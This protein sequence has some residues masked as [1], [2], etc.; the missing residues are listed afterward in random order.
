MA[1][2]LILLFLCIWSLSLLAGSA[3]EIPRSV[4]RVNV[5]TQA[6]D[7][8]QPWR[9]KAPRTRQALGAVLAD[10]RI[11]VTAELVQNHTYIEIEKPG[12]E[13]KTPAELEV[14]DYSANLALVSA[15]DPE[16]MADFRPLKLGKPP[17]VEHQVE[18]W[19]LQKNDSLLSTDALLTTVQAIMY[20]RGDLRLPAYQLT[21]SL[22]SRSGSFA[23]P[24]I[25]K[26]K[27]VGMVT[28]FSPGNQSMRAI[29]L[30]V[31]KHFFADMEDG[32]YDGFPSLGVSLSP[33]QD[34]QFRKYVGLSPQSGGV[35]ITRVAKGR[36]GEKAGLQT[37]DVI[38]KV[39]GY[40]IDQNGNY[41]HRKY[42][43]IYL[44]NLISVGCQA[45]DSLEL[46]IRRN[47]K[48]MNIA[49]VPQRK[50]PSDY[51]SPPYV[52]DT[53]P[54]YII[55]GGLVI[56]ELSQQY[57]MSW[58]KN[59]QQKAPRKLVYYDANQSSL[60]PEGDRKIVFLS[61]VLPTKATVGYSNLQQLVITKVN[62][63][64]IRSLDDVQKAL[65]NAD[66]GL[67]TFKFEDDPYQIV[68]SDDA[69]T[70]ADQM[71]RQRYGIEIM[72]R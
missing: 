4:V 67:H 25:R 32:E 11:L 49:A 62:G 56:Q 14:V 71:L 31:I 48:S 47:D 65:K 44:S 7:F 12:T 42:G 55:V 24:L 17:K 35:Y 66:E 70:K 54:R 58:G 37:G 39:N 64:A 20:P 19:Q 26:G 22:P 57:L 61:R 6:Y 45:G 68:I 34:P 16:F 28:H 15:A 59:W 43:R 23:I 3:P 21:S 13:E 63:Q 52:I 38:E 72:R 51:V 9:K 18:A 46:Q 8:L 30:S 69:A 2:K 53:P 27:L 41:E 60:F 5:T 33:T 29:P 40:D 36:P 50:A 10:N 1:R